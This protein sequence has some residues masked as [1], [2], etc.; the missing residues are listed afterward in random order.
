MVLVVIESFLVEGNGSSNG[1][2]ATVEGRHIS[3]LL[4]WPFAA[5]LLLPVIAAIACAFGRDFRYPV[6]GTS[7]A[8]YLG[9][10]AQTNAAAMNDDH[11][12]RWVAAMGH[13]SVI[14]VFWGLLA[15]VTTWVLQRRHNSFLRFQ[16]MQTTIYQAIVNVI[17]SA[18]PLSFAG[19]VPVPWRSCREAPAAINPVHVGPCCFYLSF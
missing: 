5:Y 13:F 4:L 1:T 19:M 16:S 11:Q 18:L 15:P 9:Y 8:R 3:V 12:E 10:S 6:M 17:L 7:L 2:L 14:I